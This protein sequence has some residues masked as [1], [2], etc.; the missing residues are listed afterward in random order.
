MEREIAGRLAI[1]P[2][3]EPGLEAEMRI[4]AAARHRA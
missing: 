1:G 4:G 3:Q 2:G